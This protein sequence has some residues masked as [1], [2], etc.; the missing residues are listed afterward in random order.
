VTGVARSAGRAAAPVSVLA[1]L[2]G[3]GMPAVAAAAGLAVLVVV[4]VCWVLAS[5]ERSDRVT[6]IILARHGDARCLY[7][8]AS[9][10]HETPPAPAADAAPARPGHG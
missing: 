9:A 1:L 3:L 10:E 6:R 8:S 5:R 4:A 7:L 2:A